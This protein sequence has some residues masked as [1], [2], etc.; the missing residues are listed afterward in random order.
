VSRSCLRRERLGLHG[1]VLE[2]SNG[3]RTGF[4]LENDGSPVP[5]S[6]DA[7]MQRRSGVWHEVFPEEK[8]VAISGC[9][10][11]LQPTRQPTSYLCGMV[12]LHLS[13]GRVIMCVGENPFVWPAVFSTP[14]V[15][16]A[17]G[18]GVRA[19][20]H[21]LHRRLLHRPATAYGRPQGRLK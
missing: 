3:I 13:S 7:A 15:H 16:A 8:L 14:C 4:F 6:D 20:A 19:R 10:S 18:D 2:Y 11:R 5:L 12:L 9:N 17:R 1:L 21:L